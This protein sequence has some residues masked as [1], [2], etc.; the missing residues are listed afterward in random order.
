M[1]SKDLDVSTTDPKA[2]LVNQLAL[3]PAKPLTANRLKLICASSSDIGNRHAAVLPSGTKFASTLDPAFWSNVSSQL[4][5]GDV[6]EI[7][8]DDRTFY[9]TIYVRDVSKIR[10]QVARLEFHEFSDPVQSTDASPYRVKHGGPHLKWV[11]ERIADAKIVKDGFETAEEAQAA[12]KTME[13]TLSSK[14]A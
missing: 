4:R 14:V 12:A 10:A 8:S 3:L 2:A 13:R 1:A 6:V 9:G 5:I 7:H 11:I